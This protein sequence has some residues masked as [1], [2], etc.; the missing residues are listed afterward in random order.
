[1]GCLFIYSLSPFPLPPSPSLILR[2]FLSRVVW[3][4]AEL[5]RQIEF[6]LLS[7]VWICREAVK[8]HIAGAAERAPN[9]V[10]L[11]CLQYPLIQYYP[12]HH[13]SRSCLACIPWTEGARGRHISLSLT[14]LCSSRLNSSPLSLLLTL[15]VRVIWKWTHSYQWYEDR[16]RVNRCTHKTFHL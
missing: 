8:R 13:C 5:R 1:M 2:S 7:A 11:F 3:A 12:L 6:K 16:V 10:D 4:E 15:S 14:L 9:S